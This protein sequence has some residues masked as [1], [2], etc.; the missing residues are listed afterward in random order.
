MPNFLP[1]INLLAE[2]KN[3]PRDVVVETVEAALAAAYKKDYS[4][5]DQEARAELD[6]ETGDVHLYVKKAVVDDDDI[7]NDHLE[8]GV[9]EAKKLDKKAV[10]IDVV[11]PTTDDETG[12]VVDEGTPAYMVELEVFP[13][14]FG[15]VA[16][17]TAKQVIIQRLREAEREIVFTE[18]KDKEGI[19]LNGSVQRVEGNLVYVDLGKATGVLFASEQIP[20]ERYYTGQR[21]KVYVVRV[22]QTARGPQIVLSRAHANMVKHLFELEVPELEAGTV[23]I[24]GIAREAGVRSKVA[25]KSNAAGVD[26]VGT[27]VG[28]RGSR[29]QAVMSD[30]GEEKIDIIPYAENV[31]EYIA[32]AL[33]PTKVIK[34]ELHEAEGKA[35]V[36]V[37]EDQLSL[38]IGKQGQNVRLAAK[39]TNWNIDIVSADESHVEAVAEAAATV[40]DATEGQED[41][42]IDA[43]NSGV[44][45]DPAEG[46]DPSMDEQATDGQTDALSGKEPEGD[47][48]EPAK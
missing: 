46:I 25:V 19:V 7:Q 18:Y 11:A 43:I 6:Q 41:S 27:F 38:A 31:E 14:D 21:L 23:E 8:I 3:L 20:G 13:E 47:A 48:E 37:P 5:K 40:D 42:V 34:V 9:T 36:R 39:L 28:G 12:E 26:A 1:A 29:V 15:R 10:V 17:Q 44:V 45:G 33:S 2:E 35:I 24:A 22:E 30:L 32:N 4:D 16:A